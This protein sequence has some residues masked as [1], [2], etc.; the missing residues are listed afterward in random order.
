[1]DMSTP[2][3]MTAGAWLGERLDK[4]LPPLG[5][6][7]RKRPK[8]M[9]YWADEKPPVPALLGLGLQHA[10]LALTFC[11]YAVIAGQGIGLDH[12]DLV[13]YVS[14]C[15]ALIGL[16]TLLHALRTRFTT[17]ILL[18]ALPSPVL[19]GTYV[20]VTLQYGLGATMGAVLVSSLA[21]LVF[22]RF[23]PRLR[24]FFPPEVIGVVIFMLG[25]SLIGG[26]VTRA[27]GLDPQHPLLSLPA[28]A[29]AGVTLAGI[30][31][32]SIWG[33]DR[34]RVLAVP[35]GALLGILLAWACGL[36]GGEQATQL[37]DHP[38]FA[39]PL[40]GLALPAPEFVPLAILAIF[41]P[42]FVGAVDGVA[43]SMTMDR[44]NDAGWRRP[45]MP[46]ASRAMSTTAFI[47]ILH[48]L[49][50]TL[51]SGTSSA[52]I[53]LAQATGATS[54]YIGMAAGLLLLGFAFLPQLAGLFALTPAPVIGGILI[55]TAAYMLVAGMDLILSRMLNQR[56][57][58]TVGLAIVAGSAVMLLPRLV[59]GAPAWSHTIVESGLT[60]ASLVAIALNALLRIGVRRSACTSLP[61]SAP[62]AALADFLE[63]AGM[64]WGCRRDVVMRAAGA[65]GEA[66]EA[67]QAADLVDG[68]LELSASFDEFNLTCVLA[69]PGRPLPFSSAAAPTTDALL[70]EDEDA[71]ELA[72]RQVSSVL[73]ARLA[74]RVRTSAM[75]D[76]ASLRLQFDH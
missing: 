47:N 44:M 33:N 24:S 75:E 71:F 8:D 52:N 7:R 54:R 31:G 26:G 13:T 53:G 19:M 59:E 22:A 64:T 65:L 62:A 70:G 4:A 6:A 28:L 39:V 21:I 14:G 46:M 32:L 51:T 2:R 27:T 40:L 74:D 15:I 66:I 29:C 57:I 56:R 38:S 3:R 72:M 18:V 60:L 12:Q 11:L 49:A 50:G 23:L 63:Q 9:I 10:L 25:L 16:A 48:G 30:I 73:V 41:I 68:P 34:L 1:M 42:E 35:I 69:Y 43:S 37:Q 76:R 20:A 61:A 67:L 58:F 17:G 36:L 5:S 45:D 55:Y